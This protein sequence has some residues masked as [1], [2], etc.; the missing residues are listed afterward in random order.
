MAYPGNMKTNETTTAARE[1]EQISAEALHARLAQIDLDSVFPIT[2]D[3]HC[4]RKETARLARKVM[5]LHGIKGI[6]ITAPNYSMAQSVDVS[7]PRR[8]D[9]SIFECYDRIDF[10][11]DPA[12]Q[13]NGAAAK[14]IEAILAKAFPNHDDR[15]E[16]QSDYHDYKWSVG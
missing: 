8:Q 4:G 9:Y 5:K 7:M 1:A 10:V 13:A 16:L 11:N 2:L 12:A 15:S 3:R 6:S 14:K